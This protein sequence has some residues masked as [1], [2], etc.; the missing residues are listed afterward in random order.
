MLLVF[1]LI[2]PA[3]LLPHTTF[4]PPPPLGPLS[5][6]TF[7][8]L[9]KPVRRKLWPMELLFGTICCSCLVCW[10]MDHPAT[11]PSLAQDLCGILPLLSLSCCG[12]SVRCV[13]KIFVG[14][15]KFWALPRLPST[16]LPKFRSFFLSRHYFHSFFLS[17]VSSHKAAG[18]SHDSPRTP[19]VHI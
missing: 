4:G 1:L 13:F 10:A 14:A 12:V 18:A 2:W 17:W 19:N 3:P 15:S 8:V 7:F 9:P 6:E 11:D 5:D 16:G